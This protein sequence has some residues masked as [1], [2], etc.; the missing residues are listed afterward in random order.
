MNRDYYSLSL[1]K[2]NMHLSKLHSNGLTKIMKKLL[3]A[4]TISCASILS[5]SAHAEL[6]KYEF[7][8]TIS[9]VQDSGTETKAFGLPDEDALIATPITG[10]ILIE[11]DNLGKDT[12]PADTDFDYYPYSEGNAV[13]ASFKIELTG[14]VI[15]FNMEMP[16]VGLTMNESV[17]L[18]NT[19]TSHLDHFTIKKEIKRTNGDDYSRNNFRLAASKEDFLVSGDI[20]DPLNFTSTAEYPVKSSIYIQKNINK[21]SNETYG[22]LYFVLDNLYK[23]NTCN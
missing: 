8:G 19:N 13:S 6:I 3:L 21:G 5:L 23:V 12:K 11:T 9:A 20:Q 10:T 7:N 18:R 14:Q 4:T 15:H 22:H 17:S 2:Q 1:I 16:D